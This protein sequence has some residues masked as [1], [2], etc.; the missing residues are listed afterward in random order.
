MKIPGIDFWLAVIVAVV[1]VVAGWYLFR[2]PEVAD[3]DS[4]QTSTGK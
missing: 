4:S 3:W 2:H 1:F